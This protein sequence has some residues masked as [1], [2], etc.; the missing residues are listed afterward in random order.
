MKQHTTSD[1]KK[2]S[3]DMAFVFRFLD[4][5]LRTHAQESLEYCGS[6]L[7]SLLFLQC[8]LMLS[9]KE[10]QNP[11]KHV[12]TQLPW[13]QR[14]ISLI[15]GLF[16]HLQILR[17]AEASRGEQRRLL[18]LKP[19]RPPTTGRMAS[20][21]SAPAILGPARLQLEEV[22]FQSILTPA[23]CSYSC[24]SLA[25]FSAVNVEMGIPT[26]YSKSLSNGCAKL[27]CERSDGYLS[28][29]SAMFESR[30]PHCL[31]RCIGLFL[32]PNSPNSHSH[33]RLSRWVKPQ[34]GWPTSPSL[35]SSG[36]WQLENAETMKTRG[37]PR[38]SADFRGLPRTSAFL[39]SLF[40]PNY[41]VSR[42]EDAGPS[43]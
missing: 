9:P 24:R 28:S 11:A 33:P 38:T 14:C 25:T 34:I 32:L 12:P 18:E 22:A 36:P 35:A 27:K 1:V 7:L 8:G 43:L 10:T 40:F 31:L 19:F 3:K 39:K 6:G 20:S 21:F 17:R 2:T 30:A 13:G 4:L 41:T 5:R 15:E 29:I 37:L 42:N 26:K 16:Q 23:F